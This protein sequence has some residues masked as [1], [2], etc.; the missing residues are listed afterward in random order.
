MPTRVID[1]G[2]TRD[3]RVRLHE[4]AEGETGRWV[5][6]SHK[7]GPAPHFSTNSQNLSSHLAGIEFEQLP[8]TFKDAVIVAR[9]IGVQYL[10][11]DSL[12]II[13][14]QDGDFNEEAKRMEDV[15]SGAY[16]VIAA[17]RATNH[18][19]GFLR[20]RIARDYVALNRENEAP[21]YICQMIDDFQTHVLEGRLNSRGWVLQ[22]HA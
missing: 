5:A 16:C 15:Y 9:A 7:W 2:T 20:A 13:Q 17:S 4:T 21:F 1:V 14:G 19:S 8:A 10:W 12:C 18:Y 6:L 11:I 3:A 22:E